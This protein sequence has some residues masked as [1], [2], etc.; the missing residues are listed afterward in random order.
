ME[1]DLANKDSAINIGITYFLR[2]EI[3]AFL[4]VFLMNL[5]NRSYLSPNE[6]HVK[7]HQHPWRS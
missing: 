2:N 5:L 3:S 6:K 7:E 1:R 4:T